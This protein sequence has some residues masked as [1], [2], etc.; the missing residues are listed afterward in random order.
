MNGRNQVCFLY[1]KG[2]S[3]RLR[4]VEGAKDKIL[5]HPQYILD[6]QDNKPVNL[7]EIFKNEF[8]VQIEIGM[9]KGYFI[10]TMAKQHPNINFIGIEMFDSVIIRA[11]ERVIEE[12]LENLF[13]IRTDAN[14]LPLLFP[15]QSIQRIY[16]NFSDP[17]P[18]NRHEKRRLTNPKFLD[19]YKQL[20]VSDGEIHFKTDNKK[21]FDYS[22]EVIEEYPMELTYTTRDL[23]RESIPNIRT[24]FEEKFAK[25]GKKIYKLTMKF[26]EDNNG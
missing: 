8:P 14:F 11:L 3:M 26:K 10:H 22:L 4:Y 2:G 5:A 6:N 23:H 17:W 20:L 9:G 21:L 16:L 7:Q 1:I 18:K 25:Q 24:E 13:L 15:H 12:P 19:I